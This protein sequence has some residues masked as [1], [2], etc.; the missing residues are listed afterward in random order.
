MPP[1]RATYSARLEGRG[2]DIFQSPYIL[3][4]GESN[5]RQ[6]KLDPNDVAPEGY[7]LANVGAGVALAT[8]PR[9]VHLDVSLRN[10]FDKEYQSFLS[11]Y[12]FPADPVVFD[13]G[14]NLTVRVSTDF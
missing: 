6:T 3:V 12:K 13:P 14:R 7:T 11:R 9:V 8:G 4:G 5:A 1:F 10:A 2:N